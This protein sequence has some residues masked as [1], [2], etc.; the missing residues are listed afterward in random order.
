MDELWVVA[1]IGIGL[2]AVFFV[3]VIGGA[4]VSFKMQARQLAKAS[5]SS[6]AG[7]A[8]AIQDRVSEVGPVDTAQIRQ[9]RLEK[10][11]SG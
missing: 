6:K 10:F 5:N 1:M 3:A 11:A 4:A 2:V 7:S 8:E 9:R